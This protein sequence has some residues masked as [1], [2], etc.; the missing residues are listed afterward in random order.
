MTATAVMGLETEAMRKS[1]VGLT[2]SKDL[3][4]AKP[5]PLA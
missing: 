3:R 5:K 2:G 1:E 4:L